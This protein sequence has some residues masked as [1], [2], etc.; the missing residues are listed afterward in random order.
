M[1]RQIA[2]EVVRDELAKALKTKRVRARAQR[3]KRDERLR[4]HFG[5]VDLGHATGADNAAIDADLARAYG[6]SHIAVR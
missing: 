3:A 5:A 6:A 1:I 2:H 4:R